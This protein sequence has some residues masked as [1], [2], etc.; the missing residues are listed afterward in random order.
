LEPAL[1]LHTHPVHCA[2]R[3]TLLHELDAQRDYLLVGGGLQNALIALAVLDRRPDTRLTL[4]EREPQLGGNHTWGFHVRDVPPRARHLIE[5][6]VVKRWPAHDVAF[7]AHRRRIPDEYAVLTSERLHRAVTERLNDAPQAQ[8]LTAKVVGLD[9][10]SV[11]LTDGRCLRARRIIDARGPTHARL[12]AVGGY[13]K[14]LGLELRVAPG[15]APEVPLLM[16]ATVEQHD[17]FRFIYLL[18]WA[19]DRVLIEDTY[20]SSD[21]RLDVDLLRERI[22]GYAAHAGLRVRGV[23]REEQGVLPIPTALHFDASREGPLRAGYAGGLFHPTTGYSLPVA[24]RFALLLAA[25]PA[26]AALGAEYARWISEHRRQVRF[27]LWLNRL[28]FGAFAP[29]RRYHVL[30]R[31]YRLPL[32]TIRR[33]YALETTP[34]DRARVLCGH[35]PR[36]F[37]L[38]RLLAGDPPHERPVTR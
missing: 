36:G 10:G 21:A 37:S 8:I 32:D 19:E 38:G 30:E 1:Q 35:P 14:F 22:L 11:R 18:P 27:C 26:D 6:L 31:F 23:L 5:P 20:Y 28:L 4:I 34:I 25:Q 13:Q 9:P 3:G 24:L 33:F 2:P 15:T 12:R 7:P 16:D 29:E 17:G